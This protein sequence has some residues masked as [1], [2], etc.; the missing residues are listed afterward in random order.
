TAREDKLRLPGPTVELAV[1]VVRSAEYVRILGKACDR[2]GAEKQIACGAD[3]TKPRCDC[4][5]RFAGQTP[6]GERH[7]PSRAAP[8]ERVRCVP[9]TQRCLVARVRVRAAFDPPFPHVVVR[10]DDET[11]PTTELSAM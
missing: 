5:V 1:A 6:D 3:R 11:G 7:D 9:R 4:L 10:H 8:Q 2:T